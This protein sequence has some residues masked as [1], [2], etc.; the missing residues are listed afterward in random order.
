MLTTNG[1]RIDLVEALAERRA[2][3]HDRQA[4]GA[5]MDHGGFDLS[6]Y[7]L[8]ELV[9]TTDAAELA[10]PEDQRQV[11][12]CGGHGGTT[13]FERCYELSTGVR[14]QFSRMYLYLRGKAQDQIRGDNGM[15]ISGGIK[16]MREGGICTE[17]L[18]PYPG[19]YL[20]NIPAGADAEA[21][22]Y[23]LGSAID[24]TADGDPNEL[25][26]RYL[27]HNMGA[28][29]N[30]CAWTRAMANPVHGVIEEWTTPSR[31]DGGHAWAFVGLSPR[32]DARGRFYYWLANSHSIQWGNGG[33]AELSPTA[34]AAMCAHQWTESFAISNPL[35]PKRGK[36]II[37]NLAA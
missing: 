3:L 9:R 19:R 1:Y 14:V 15:T 34:Y 20:E 17:A 26:Q 11:N 36:K 23:L 24:A 8:D 6:V 4:Y 13:A 27:G 29:Y 28:F 7:T 25:A 35:V 31:A 12:S 16:Q 18:F 33:F 32:Q 22:Q 2:L 21:K 5:V 30:G 10:K 37:W